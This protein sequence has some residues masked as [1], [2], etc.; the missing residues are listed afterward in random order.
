[1]NRISFSS[2]TD[3]DSEIILCFEHQMIP[4]WERYGMNHLAVSKPTLKEFREQPLSDLISISS[5][6]RTKRKAVVHKGKGRVAR[7]WPED[8]QEALHY[9]TLAYVLSGEAEFRLGDYVV[10]CPQQHF[11]LLSAGVPQPTGLQPYLE[12]PRRGKKCEI[13][14][15]HASVSH[16]FI[17]LSVCYSQEEQQIN[18]GH[19]YVITDQRISQ[20]F[21]IFVQ[22]VTEKSEGYVK[23]ANGL[24]HLFLQM[25]LR[26]IKQG[27]FHTRGT[28]ALRKSTLPSNSPIESARQYVQ[29]NLKHP[30]TIDV[31]ARSVFMG[32]TGFATLFHKETGQTFLEYL[33]ERRLE[34]AKQ[35][36][37]HETCSIEVVCELVGL[38]R[39]QFHQ[40][41]KRRF[42]MTPKEFHRQNKKV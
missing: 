19:F 5:K 7:S 4:V 32:R 24:F 27:N 30:L 36:L 38:K 22:E 2:I 34:E 28:E 6:K 40:L 23:T 17:A 13:W 11:L 18:S 21:H 33:T 8:D 25:F 31:V 10:H 20:L 1:M 29:K 3:F 16:A 41:F 37:L 14:W 12:S 9:P 35:Y 15:F 42:G 39:T 26:E